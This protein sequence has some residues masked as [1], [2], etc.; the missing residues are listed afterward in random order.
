MGGRR[1][2]RWVAMAV[3]SGLLIGG[4]SWRLAAASAS[5]ENEN[6]NE[7]DEP[8]VEGSGQGS[9][10]RVPPGEL[11]LRVS[12][13]RPETVGHVFATLPSGTPRT[14]L[15]DPDARVWIARFFVDRG[16]RPGRYDLRVD[17]VDMDGRTEHVSLPCT[18]D[19]R[20]PAVSAT[21]RRLRRDTAEFQIAAH[22]ILVSAERTASGTQ[23]SLF[24][25]A[26][27]VEVRTPDGQLVTLGAKDDGGRAFRGRW[28]AHRHVE[29]ALKLRFV[30][31]DRALDEHVTDLSFA[32]PAV[33]R[34]ADGLAAVR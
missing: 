3:L 11:E 31:V 1:R 29:G 33:V 2:A 28:S 13:A 10:G 23:A 17:V 8:S 9:P 6:E 32:L 30:A 24:A 15:Y 22:G 7:N 25:T 26:R 20:A 27:H 18:I 34:A 12:V 4:W 19:P 16:T 5:A 21:L 14:G